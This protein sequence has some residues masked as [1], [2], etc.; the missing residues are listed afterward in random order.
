MIELKD[1]VKRYSYEEMAENDFQ[2]Q[3]GLKYEDELDLFVRVEVLAYSSDKHLTETFCTEDEYIREVVYRESNDNIKHAQINELLKTIQAEIESYVC[4]FEMDEIDEE[5]KKRLKDWYAG[6]LLTECCNFHIYDNNL[7]DSIYFTN[8]S[9]EEIKKT[10]DNFD[11][12]LYIDNEINTIN[13]AIIQ[14]I[15]NVDYC[16]L[17]EVFKF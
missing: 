14:L 3:A 10:L 7:T 11:I 1:D 6:A 2:T 9:I 5:E 15:G 13:D 16:E 4:D 17:D 12:E 8:K